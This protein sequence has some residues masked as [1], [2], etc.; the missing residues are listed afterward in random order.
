[1]VH[2][3]IYI[4][5]QFD[6]GRR[7]TIRGQ[8]ESN[9]FGITLQSTADVE[10]RSNAPLHVAV[11]LVNE[12]ITRNDWCSVQGWKQ[13]ENDGGCPITA[14]SFFEI[15][16]TVNR[17]S[18]GIT[19]NGRHFSDFAHRQPF[20]MVRFIHLTEGAQVFAVVME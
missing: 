7:V 15:Q 20:D 16:I 2:P 8:M 13:E 9:A 6:V 5:F 10:P 11:R 17:D 19:V 1:M 12:T 3:A 14:G 4:P 18:Y